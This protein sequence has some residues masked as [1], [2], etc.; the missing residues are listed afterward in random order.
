MK[1]APPCERMAG[2]E[3]GCGLGLGPGEAAAFQKSCPGPKCGAGGMQAMGKQDPGPLL[4][5]GRGMGTLLRLK[6]L[7]SIKCHGGVG[8]YRKQPRLAVGCICLLLMQWCSRHQL[9]SALLYQLRACLSSRLPAL[10]SPSPGEE[11]GRPRC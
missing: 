9:C 11:W 4:S 5:G 2:V 6:E 8:W 7:P 3:Q 10:P 1:V